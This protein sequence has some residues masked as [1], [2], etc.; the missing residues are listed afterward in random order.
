MKRLLVIALVVSMIVTMFTGCNVKEENKIDD[1]T[2]RTAILE[3]FMSLSEIPRESGH[4]RPISSYLRSWAKQ[5]NFTVIRDK[6]N[7]VIIDKP[8]TPGYEDAPTTILQC[9]MDMLCAT[10]EGIYFDPLN[11]PIKITDNGDTM[12]AENTSLG[13][14]SGIGI[15][16]ALYVLKN[17]KM[18]G[19]LRVIFTADGETTM[20]GAQKLNAKY[21]DGDYLINLGW[22]TVN[23]IGNGSEGTNAYT[24]SRA[25]NWTAPK[26]VIPYE[27]SIKGLK[28]GEAESEINKGGANAIKLIGEALAKAQ[29]EGVLLELGAFNSGTSGDTIPIDAVALVIINESDKKKFENTMKSEID[30]FQHDYGD[31]EQNAVFSYS[32]SV[33]PDK[34]VSW[35]DSSS[36]LSFVYGVLNGVQTTTATG[37][38]ESYTNLGSVSTYTG[39]FIAQVFAGSSSEKG[40]QE[41]TSAHEAV[42]SMCDLKY[43]IWELTPRWP[44]NPDSDLVAKLSEINKAL[45]GEEIGGK[46]LTRE[47]ECGWFARKNPDL[48]IASIGPMILHAGTTEETLELSTVTRPATVILAF[49][50]QMKES[51]N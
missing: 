14:D 21:L 8:A 43:N 3:E 19:P 40:A 17:A 24:M 26:N 11:D 4:I 7:N 13:A 32:Q 12:T 28:G 22:D 2:I 49:L 39:S 38:A 15:S 23:S 25:I 34:V 5:N 10:T 30:A 37:D 20:A 41:I 45:Y 50:E 18:H 33:M 47:T 1:E 29:G 16:T 48:K 31:V 9:N 44:E 42:S 36:I 27:V 46:A 51:T 35:D 6:S